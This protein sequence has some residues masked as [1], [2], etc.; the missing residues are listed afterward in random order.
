[1]TPKRRKKSPL[2]PSGFSTDI[3]MIKGSANT[4]TRRLLWADVHFLMNITSLYPEKVIGTPPLST[5][6]P[7]MATPRVCVA[8]DPRSYELNYI[9]EPEDGLVKSP[10]DT[11]TETWS[12]SK[13][14]VA[15]PH[16]IDVSWPRI[17]SQTK[18]KR[19]W[20]PRTQTSRA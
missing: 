13:R 2:L 12:K 5:I 1:M 8:S 17:Q 14:K 20:S 19:N 6:W 4:P 18:K 15:W 7:H 16:E 9:P 3:K 11:L 10:D